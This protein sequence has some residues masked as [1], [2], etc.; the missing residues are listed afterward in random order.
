MSVAQ[1]VFEVLGQCI[2]KCRNGKGVDGSKWKFGKIKYVGVVNCVVSCMIINFG[3]GPKL[4]MFMREVWSTGWCFIGLADSSIWINNSER[5]V[6]WVL[7]HHLIVVYHCRLQR[8]LANGC[9]AAWLYVS[10][11]YALVVLD[12]W[13]WKYKEFYVSNKSTFLNVRLRNM[14]CLFFT[15]PGM[16]FKRLNCGVLGSSSWIF[17]YRPSCMAM[18]SNVVFLENGVHLHGISGWEFVKFESPFCQFCMFL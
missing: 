18:C 1:Y 4:I 11:K 10:E 12:G 17:H 7:L 15:S 16:N 3:R 5:W 6:V 13:I 8:R 2:R 14:A 9:A